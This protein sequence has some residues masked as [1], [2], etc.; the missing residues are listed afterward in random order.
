MEKAEKNG[1]PTVFIFKGLQIKTEKNVY[2]NIAW[3]RNKEHSFKTDDCRSG[4]VAVIVRQTNCLTLNLKL[5]PRF[6]MFIPYEKFDDSIICAYKGW[7]RSLS[8]K[9]LIK[10]YKYV[11]FCNSLQ[12]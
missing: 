1:G 9:P 12:F 11:F 2:S 4:R 6:A 5:R 8:L 10:G 7:E 3:P